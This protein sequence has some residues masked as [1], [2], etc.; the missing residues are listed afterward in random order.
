MLSAVAQVVDSAAALR[1]AHPSPTDSVAVESPLPGGV[2][3]VVR[4]LLNS[5]PP[6]IQIGGVVLAVLVGIAL[7]VLLIRKRRPIGAWLTTRA[8]GTQ[9]AL[10]AAAAVLLIAAGGMGAATWNYTQHSNDF[11]VGCH[12][13]NP[14]FQEFG[15][16]ENEHAELSCHDC[17]QQPLSA[18]A[19]QLYLWVAERPEEI[20]EH[21]KVPNEICATCHITGDTARW[22]RV[23]STAG[24][25]VHLE[26]DS[27]ALEDLQCVTCHGVEVHRFRPVSETC[28]A[29]GCHESSE[30][31]I[32]LGK[33]ADQTIRHCTSCHE[34]TADVPALATRDSARGTL[35]PGMS[36]CL[37]CHE[38]QRVLADF[39]PADDPH[40]GS[41][42]TCH[43]P[44]EQT[45]PA[46]AANTC[47]TA[48]C[49]SSWRDEP[50][51]VGASHR[52]VGEQC[53]VCHQPHSARVDASECAGCHR[54]VRD[55]S[56]LRPPL[57]FDTTSALRRGG[58]TMRPMERAPR[59]P[60]LVRH[61]VGG[62]AP[63][64]ASHVRFASLAGGAAPAPARMRQ[65]ASAEHPR[66]P[67]APADTFS[68]ARHARLACLVCHATTSGDARL[69]FTPPRGCAICHHQAPAT[70]RCASCHGAE[71]LGAPQ[72]TELT[73]T[74][75]G[76]AARPRPVPFLHE[77]H[78]TVSCLTCHTAPV[79]LAAPAPIAQCADCHDDHH[80]VERSCASCHTIADPIAG[81][82]TLETAHTRCDACHTPATVARLTPT[83]TFCITCHTAQGASHYEPRECTTC[84]FLAEP[85][86]FRARIVTV[87]PQ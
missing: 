19:R 42:G 59:D 76:A 75:E 67:P 18:S 69:T 14:A 24:H 45:T 4:F 74:V 16:D 36:Q 73:V 38:M 77:G 53:L 80:T 31:G 13:M 5:V 49:H 2:A 48:G 51:H 50:F 87:P 84:H 44:H 71:E 21:A 55:Q 62:P 40:D 30:T 37:G 35:V 79:T 82:A 72:P 68:H 32:V 81:H 66:A 7:L 6:W 23:A 9:I 28:G 15:S 8:R 17:H 25:R 1:Q 33:M 22:Q 10:A 39:D 70:S 3:Q 12:V 85:A 46:E 52:R 57:P 64:F 78:A 60:S 83:R 29:S 63:A 56:R 65:D 20:G 43:N 58:I 47:A 41:C 27:S 34:F 61:A 54:T 26:S 11:C 86:D